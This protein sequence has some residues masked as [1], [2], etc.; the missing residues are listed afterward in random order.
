MV[1]VRVTILQKKSTET[2]ERLKS[3]GDL[4]QDYEK[5]C[6]IGK[7]KKN[8][9]CH[10][11]INKSLIEEENDVYILQKC[12][13]PELN[14]LHGLVNHVFWT[15]VVIIVGREKVL[16]WKKKNLADKAESCGEKLSWLDC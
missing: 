3:Y 11:I 7:S 10:S 14:L 9:L 1:I 16:T 4:G 13:L 12:V 6:W 5:Y 15:G 2:C 8:K